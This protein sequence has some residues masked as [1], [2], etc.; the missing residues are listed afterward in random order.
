V[1]LEGEQISTLQS[2]KYLTK[3][4]VIVFVGYT[5]SGMQV[6]AIPAIASNYAVDSYK[7]VAGSLFVVITVLKNLWCYGLSKWLTPFITSSGYVKPIMLNMCL[8]V[9]WLLCSVG[10]YYR[11]K[12]FRKW[13]AKS[14][15]HDH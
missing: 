9:F 7:V 13:T 11:G 5:C 8:Y 14:A 12:T 1:E 15:V 3:V 6:A 4:K 10:F 2:K